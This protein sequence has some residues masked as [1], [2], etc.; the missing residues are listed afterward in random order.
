MDAGRIEAI[1]TRRFR[2]ERAPTLAASA[3]SGAPIAFTRLRYDREGHGQAGPVPGEDSF[4]F[5]VMLK[6]LLSWDLTTRRGH[7]SL[8]PAGAGDVFLFDLNDDPRVSLDTPFDMVRFYMPQA[9]LDSLAYERG[10]RRVGGLQ[11]PASGIHDPIMH[12]MALS[13]AASMVHPAETQA[14]F[15]DYMALAFHAHAMQAFG[16]SPGDRNRRGG[17]A[18]AQLQRVR[19]AMEAGLDRPHSIERLAQE[20]GLSSSHFAH[21]FKQTTGLAPH[22]WLTRRRIERARELLSRT[23]LELADIAL[24]CGFVDQS[25][26]SRVFTRIEK[27]S[28]G[29]WRREAGTASRQA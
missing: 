26:F 20:C 25:H 10:A 29:R 3:S 18:P 19:E 12:G 28:P 23:G 13:L 14:L 27:A 24:A 15:V 7:S 1:M 17:L 4:A 2:L 9:S 5:Q 11:A 16:G 8:P 21:A 22:Q 6:P